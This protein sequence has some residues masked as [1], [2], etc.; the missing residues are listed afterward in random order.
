[1]RADG[2]RLLSC[3][4]KWHGGWLLET[5]N[6]Q[7]PADDV[8]RSR[9]ARK[10]RYTLDTW[11]ELTSAPAIS[12]T[13]TTPCAGSVFIRLGSRKGY[14]LCFLAHTF[15]GLRGGAEWKLS[16]QILCHYVLHLPWQT[17]WLHIIWVISLH[18]YAADVSPCQRA[19]TPSSPPLDKARRRTLLFFFFFKVLHMSLPSL[20]SFP[21]PK[22]AIGV[23]RDADPDGGKTYFNRCPCACFSGGKK[24]RSDTVGG[25]QK[26][27]SYCI[28]FLRSAW[29][30]THPPRRTRIL[31]ALLEGRQKDTNGRWLIGSWSK[32]LL[33]YWYHHR[34]NMIEIAR[35]RNR[36]A[37]S[38]CHL[39]W[40]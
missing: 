4:I 7:N 1:M 38:F 39:A 18:F 12:Q 3:Q 36:I 28:F 10:A 2:G 35:T 30:L 5:D 33:W 15:L 17:L 11:S 37:F 8:C 34:C 13:N 32:W 25:E 26:A 24:C 27:V 19:P 31:E 21:L 16:L 9:R 23:P 22:R 6:K 14:A 40:G 20:L 29:W